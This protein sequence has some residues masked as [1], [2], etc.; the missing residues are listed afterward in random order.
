MIL[1]YLLFVIFSNHPTAE[2]R[3]Y[4]RI[5]PH[6]C[7]STPSRKAKKKKQVASYYS[8][9]DSD[10]DNVFGNNDD[11]DDAPLSNLGMYITFSLPNV[12]K[13]YSNHFLLFLFHF[14]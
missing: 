8:H 5:Q 14:M 9:S 2:E 13:Y 10:T 1:F 6:E 7:S 3:C 4:R 12:M 11:D